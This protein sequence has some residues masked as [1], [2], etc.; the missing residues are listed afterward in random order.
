MAY[1]RLGTTQQLWRSRNSIFESSHIGRVVG[2][3]NTAF[4]HFCGVPLDILG[5]VQRPSQEQHGN[6]HDSQTGG[7]KHAPPDGSDTPI[8]K[9][10]SF[11][12]TSA[13]ATDLRCSSLVLSSPASD[14]RH[15]L[16]WVTCGARWLVSFS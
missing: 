4:Q 9:D 13:S 1:E 2:D 5:C 12:S 14:S 6:R 16:S 8:H 15:W 11:S 10:T 3:A 7:D